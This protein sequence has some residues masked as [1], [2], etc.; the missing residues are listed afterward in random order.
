[1]RILQP[2]GHAAFIHPSVTYQWK[3]VVIVNHNLFYLQRRRY[4]MTI[5]DSFYFALRQINYFRD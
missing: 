3:N 1:M 5:A 4:V 2:H